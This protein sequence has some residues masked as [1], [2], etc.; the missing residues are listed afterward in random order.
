MM[1]ETYIRAIHPFRTFYTLGTPFVHFSMRFRSTPYQKW[2]KSPNLKKKLFCF[3]IVFSESCVPYSIIVRSCRW[4]QMSV[5]TSVGGHKCRWSQVSRHRKLYELRIFFHFRI[6]HNVN[7]VY[8]GNTLH[9]FF[10]AVSQY[11]VDPFRL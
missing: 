11:I 2:G 10:S 8:C 9:L 6:T 4:A 1:R 3:S 5:F 7:I